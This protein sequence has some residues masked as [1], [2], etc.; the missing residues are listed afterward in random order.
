MRESLTG[1]FFVCFLSSLY[2]GAVSVMKLCNDR[3]SLS[4]DGQ[5]HSHWQ[6]N[7]RATLILLLPPPSKHTPIANEVVSS[8]YIDPS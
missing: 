4:M 6:V 8:L 5:N 7:G 1:V 3:G 2:F